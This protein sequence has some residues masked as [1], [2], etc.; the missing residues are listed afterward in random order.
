MANVLDG[1]TPVVHTASMNKAP[2]L[3]WAADL[4][5]GNDFRGAS[6]IRH[7]AIRVTPTGDHLLVETIDCLGAPDILILDS[8][9]LV[10]L[11]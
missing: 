4:V 6:P 5:A 8:D 9:Q 1:A 7:R 10:E 2:T 11:L 3:V